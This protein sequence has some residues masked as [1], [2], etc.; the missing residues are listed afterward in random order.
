[1]LKKFMILTLTLIASWSFAQAAPSAQP[2]KQVSQAQKEAVQSEKQNTQTEKKA[3]PTVEASTVKKTKQAS[4]TEQTPKK[5]VPPVKQPVQSEKKVEQPAKVAAPKKVEQPATKTER[6]KKVEQP[7]KVE[8]AKPAPAVPTVE[9]PAATDSATATSPA[10]E[11][12][13]PEEKKPPVKKEKPTC[14]ID[15]NE[16][17]SSVSL[18]TSLFK[19]RVTPWS[20]NFDIIKDQVKQFV[21]NKICK[22]KKQTC[23]I[24]ARSGETTISIDDNP[25]SPYN[26]DARFTARDLKTIK[27]SELC[28]Y[29]E[30]TYSI[31]NLEDQYAVYIDGNRASGYSANEDAARK[32]L[33]L[34]NETLSKSL[35]V[36]SPKTSAPKAQIEGLN[37]LKNFECWKGVTSAEQD[38][39][40]LK[41]ERKMKSNQICE[42]SKFLHDGNIFDVCLQG[43]E[44]KPNVVVQCIKGTNATQKKQNLKK[45]RESLST[46]QICESNW[47]ILGQSWPAHIISKFD[48]CIM[49]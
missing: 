22:F 25:I 6:P 36:T 3:T 40:K 20:D 46:G 14:M 44:N 28:E 18:N 47:T 16:G 12:K 17:Y 42:T 19:R 48:V 29:V 30:P 8:A 13:P 37:K 38:K 27:E 23:S 2:E 39:N 43:F 11:A 45:C 31:L 41:C 49:E 9:T 26:K 15:A 32:D 24:I 5:E 33:A 1:M 34:F 21:D 10:A 4:K 7:K 35:P